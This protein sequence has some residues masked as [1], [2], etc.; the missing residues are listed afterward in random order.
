MLIGSRCFPTA[1]FLWAY[2]TNSTVA[3][4][5]ITIKIKVNKITLFSIVLFLNS[6]ITVKSTNPI[7]KLRK[8]QS[9]KTSCSVAVFW[10]PSFKNAITS[11]KPHTISHKK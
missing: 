11:R 3:I 5:A 9:L 10:L 6:R 4:A 8:I 7:N 2:F 1:V